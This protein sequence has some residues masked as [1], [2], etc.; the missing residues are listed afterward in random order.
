MLVAVAIAAAVLL[1]L[2]GCVSWF[3]PPT[4]RST[5]TPTGEEVAADLKPYYSQVLS[6]KS[7]E[8]G[9]QCSTAKAPLDW[10]NP[11]AGDIELAL[12]RKTATGTRLG[13]LL[14][15]PGG[16]GGSGY[17]FIRDSVD[18][19]TDARLQSSFD[20]VGFD[21]RGVNHSTPVTCY[22]DPAELD[23][24][25]YD[26]YPG[27]PGN[28]EWLAAANDTMKK[29]GERC[30]ELTG[31]LLANVDTPSAARDLDMLR[32]ALGDTTLNYLGYSYGTLLGQVY[33]ELF[34]SKTGRLVLDGAVDP[35]ASDFDGTATQAKG[36]ESALKAFLTDCGS[37]K[38][39]PFSGTVDQDLLDIRALLDNLDASPLRNADDGRQLGSAAMFTAI[40][41]PLYNADNWVYLRQL[42]TLVKQGDAAYAFQLADS[43]NGRNPD[44]S[45]ADN[46]TEAFISINCLDAHGDGNV[47]EMRAE[48]AKLKLIAPV[49]GP[50]MSWGGTG[51]P[52][53][54]VPAKRDRVPIVAAGSADI[55]VV[56]TTNDP[57]TPYSWAQ[58]VA[59]TLENGHLITYTGEGHTAYNKSNSCVNDAV[60]DYFVKGTVPATDPQC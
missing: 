5:S 14:V 26:I 11:G 22:K 17:D 39:C 55:L 13:S 3:L 4:S 29:F 42:F 20:I 43:Y 41:L 24:Y 2:S 34:P 30:L 1:P 59:S 54:P 51:C 32:A 44:G 27:V 40:I 60:D 57:A 19:A 6:W 25:L 8:T 49:F 45:Y 21:P 33:A 28:D 46:Q 18:Y 31:P 10:S 38:D 52:N 15:N 7:C 53:W 16:P 47:D 48:A 23:S 37:Q 12:I 9:M 56:G 36:F 35:A 58:T 50:Q